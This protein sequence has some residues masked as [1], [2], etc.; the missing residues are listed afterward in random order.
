MYDIVSLNNKLLT[1]LK[2]IA[3]SLDIKKI[4]SFKKQELI[5]KI[6]DAQAIKPNKSSEKAEKAEK[7]QK[8]EKA[9]K[10]ASRPRKRIPLSSSKEKQE[11]EAGKSAKESNTANVVSDAR[12]SIKES[13][14]DAP[15]GKI[16]AETGKSKTDHDEFQSSSRDNDFEKGNEAIKFP[17]I[18]KDIKD[19]EKH[20]PIKPENRDYTTGDKY[21][22]NKAIKD[23]IETTR[24]SIR[25]G[26]I[27]ESSIREGSIRE[28]SIRESSGRESSG[29]EGSSRESSG[30]E[31]SGRESSIREGNIREGSG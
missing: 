28:S 31:S 6:L 29:R 21:P 5:Y 2:E 4:D 25:E 14:V 12:Q 23:P 27:R 9:E 11:K 26:S 24:S 15:K 19:A 30:R 8:S 18:H 13:S 10:K 17:F 22:R 1:E 16:S 3:R 7:T 20:L